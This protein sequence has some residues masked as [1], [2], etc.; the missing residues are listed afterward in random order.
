M[1]EIEITSVQNEL[2]KFAVKLQNAKFR[3]KQK[4]I[5]VDGDKSI[6]G[7]VND[8]VEFE[9]IFLKKDNPYINKVIAKEI[10][11]V[12]DKIL[13][14][15]S[16]VVSPSS[17]VGIIKEPKILV[18]EF[19]NFKK[20]ALL[21]GIKDAGNLGTII[22]SAS[23]FSIDG[24]LLIND[25]VDIYN[26]KTIR[27]AAQNMFK[28]PVA[29]VDLDFIKL[30]KKTHVLISTVVNSNN[31]FMDY[32]FPD[33]FIV[34]FGSEANGLSNEI[35]ELSDEKI[36]LF[37]DNEVESLNLAVCSSVVFALIKLNQRFILS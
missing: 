8:G 27:A 21:D 31:D 22:R 10:I 17:M 14:K 36:T 37:M 4:L 19:I 13:E 5:F 20:I 18:D 12:N 25:C 16:S 2:V 24:I 9:Y 35:V 6:I 26:P 1:K 11:Y 34:A 33:K 28:I 23:A 30:L 3:K 15:I 29:K 7:L 32:N